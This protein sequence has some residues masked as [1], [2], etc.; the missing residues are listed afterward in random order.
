MRRKTG[1]SYTKW[2]VIG[3]S[4]LGAI[5]IGVIVVSLVREGKR[6]ARRETFAKEIDSYLAVTTKV[7]KDPYIN[8]KIVVVNVRDKVVDEDVYSALPSS[9]QAA[10]PD[11]V[12]TVVL[13]KWGSISTGFTV[14]DRNGKLGPSERVCTCNLTVIDNSIPAIVGEFYIGGKIPSI[15]PDPPK[16]VDEVID[17]L[18]HLPRETGQESTR[19]GWLVLFCSDDPSIWNTDH[20]GDSFAVPVRR[21]DRRIRY[22]RLKRMDTQEF[23]IIP[24][25]IQDLQRD[26]AERPVKG[27][28]WNGKNEKDWGGYHL[29]IAQA[30]PASGVATGAIGVSEDR[31]GSGFG[32][33][34]FVNDKQYYS[35][36]GLEIPKTV[37]EIAVTADALSA[38]ENAKLL[39]VSPSSKKK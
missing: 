35:W 25:G 11:E 13:V 31:P 16:T 21:A 4:I 5:V 7:G 39:T 24:I 12:G 14:V 15:A 34:T 8:G 17:F 3:G 27:Y 1:S 20:P 18:V 22:L 32:H 29:G 26:T 2:F 36:K 9:L 6:T 38:D 30:P 33:K 19:K 23:M 28:R 10:G 37:F